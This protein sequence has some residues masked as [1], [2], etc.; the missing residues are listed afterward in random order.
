MQKH[1][2][3]KVKTAL[4]STPQDMGHQRSTAAHVSPIILFLTNKQQRSLKETDNISRY[5][6]PP[7]KKKQFQSQIQKAM[8]KKKWE[9][10]EKENV[11]ETKNKNWCG[12]WFIQSH[13]SSSTGWQTHRPFLAQEE[14][15][16]HFLS[17]YI[18]S[19]KLIICGSDPQS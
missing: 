7:S 13:A 14:L 12:W 1:K 3:Q 19:T 16:Q 2:I 15:W 6:C 17:S 4:F 11:K 10:E 18:S 8:G 5:C 9:W